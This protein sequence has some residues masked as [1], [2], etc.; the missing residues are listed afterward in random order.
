MNG[1]NRLLAF[2]SARAPLFILSGAL[3]LSTAA[4]AVVLRFDPLR[5]KN[6]GPAAHTYLS[7]LQN[8][9]ISSTTI[10]AV[11]LAAFLFLGR[12]FDEI[13]ARL[14][15]FFFS[16]SDI[17]K[18][19]LILI[20]C[21]I[22]AFGSHAGNIVNGY[23]NMDDFEVVGLSHRL[24]FTEAL[25]T[26]HGNDHLIPLFR[27]EMAA[28]GS[29]FGQNPLPHNLFFFALFALIPFFVYLAFKR[30]GLS[31]S[32][33]FVFLVVFSG[34]ADWADML[35]GFNIMNIYPQVLL[36]F[37]M[38]SWAYLAWLES[39]EKKFLLIFTASIILALAIDTSG[40]WTIPVLFFLMAGVFWR[41]TES[42]GT[43]SQKFKEFF[44]KNKA[45]LASLAGVALAY[46]IFFT[47]TFTVI[48]PHT[49]LTTLTGD[50][51]VIADEKSL[52]WKS[53]P[54]AKDFIFS[55]PDVSISMFAP[56]AEKILAHP[57]F[58][59]STENP[60]RAFQ[61][62]VLAANVTLFW[63]AF[64][65][66]AARERKF[67]LY[68]LAS[69]FLTVAM[70]VVARPNHDVIRNID[71][72]YSGPPY[73]FYSIFLGLGAG[74]FL[75][76]KKE[77][78][79]KIIVAAV[80]VIF[81]TTQA[82]GFQ[83]LRLKEEA[84]M[85]KAAIE[86]LNASLLKE[87]E[88]MSKNNPLSVPN[89]TGGHIFQESLA[90]F[91]LA[92][93]ILFFNKKMPVE[94][95][96]NRAMPPDVKTH[97]VASVESLRSAVS[98]DFKDRLAQAGAIRAYYA[99]P[100]LLDYETGVVGAGA[101]APVQNKTGNVIVESGTFDPEKKHLLEFSLI[102][103]NAPG[104]LEIL[105]SFKNDFG[106]SETAGKIRVDDYTPYTPEDGRRMYRVKTDLLQIYAYALSE[107]VSDLTLN[108]P[109]TKNTM[110]NEI[111]LR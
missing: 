83:A 15:N 91:T 1:R 12:R 96:Q 71:Y 58:K 6:F 37:S 35:S 78:A 16:L 57:S 86:R 53:L 62:L 52:S 27:A 89:L 72:R 5:L 94:L 105:L 97:T 10:L 21:F 40:V 39:R 101:G 19:I 42:G 34:A 110:V 44:R 7:G 69:I 102:T 46:A 4:L 104:N 80:I 32:G 2:V 74:I 20:T 82:M 22:F 67:M 26:P 63:I 31:M 18:N 106:V 47:A 25:L 23:F 68:L 61:I 76:L 24:P 33:F 28:L 38:A 84:K 70:V 93:Y 14:R 41:R 30:L 109:S 11:V 90:G 73:Y 13:L 98:G 56:N 100:A 103:D 107:K 99:S 79:A 9:L 88:T 43:A 66:A 45:P 54:L 60:W 87:L 55:L 17:R 111:Y 85:R 8:G 81:A 50:E 49:F 95:I 3:I 36:F 65:Y 108:I 29:L 77:N 75:K 48:Q 51:R 59:N 92:D 64:K